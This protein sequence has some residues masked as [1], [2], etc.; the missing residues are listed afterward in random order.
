MKI[1][2]LPTMAGRKAGGV[3]TYE[4][5]LIRAL[6]RTD[7]RNAYTIYALGPNTAAALDPKQDNFKVRVMKPSNRILSMSTTLPLSLSRAGLNVCHA[8]FVPPLVPPKKLVY[9][10][11]CMSQFIRPD[12]YPWHMRWRI[13]A[14]TKIGMKFAELIICVSEDIRQSALEDFKIAPDRLGVVHNGIDDCF[15]PVKDTPELRD[16]LRQAF[17]IDRPYILFAGKL[18]ARKNIIGL[19]KAFDCFRKETGGKHRLVL[20]GRPNWASQ[21]IDETIEELG[22]QNEII[23]TGHLTLD[24]LPPLYSGA[25]VFVF[26]SFWEGFGLPVAE[27][28]ACGVPVITSNLSAMPEVAG[29]AAMLIDPKRVED[30]AAAIHKVCTDSQLRAQMRAAG[31]KRARQ[32]SWDTVARQTIEAYRKI[33]A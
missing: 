16:H 32:F 14:L 28:M 18:E 8:T 12:L 27:A 17:G 15:A 24:Q 20:A 25:D 23:R 7:D 5:G 6:S 3:E 30:I 21:G 26:P 13:N 22:L 31:L 2:I 1:G 33:A 29:G 9:T 19:V 11:H 10:L 4:L